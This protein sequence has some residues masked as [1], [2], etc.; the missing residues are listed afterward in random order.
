MN[1]SR[2]EVGWWSIESINLS[3]LVSR[4]KDPVARGRKTP[5]MGTLYNIAVWK[6]RSCNVAP[7]NSSSRHGAI[8]KKFCTDS[9][10]SRL[11]WLRCT[12]ILMSSSIALSIKS[13]NSESDV[14]FRP[15]TS[16]RTS[17]SLT[18]P[19]DG[20]SGRIL[21]A[22]NKPEPSG[23]CLW[24]MCS[25]K[26]RAR[27]SAGFSSV[28]MLWIVPLRILCPDCTDCKARRGRSRGNRRSVDAFSYPPATNPTA[29]PSLVTTGLPELPPLTSADA[30][31]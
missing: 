28:H 25:L 27:H 24:I 14:T 21:L 4:Q 7:A 1:A 22:T 13:S 6:R 26:P 9:S 12:R 15:L 31:R 30:W 16:R 10:N 19:S 17:P 18:L 3:E 23:L 20:P 8:L 11:F 29:N 5:L 2:S